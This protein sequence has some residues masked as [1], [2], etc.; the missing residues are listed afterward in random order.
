M[1][2]K[3]EWIDGVIERIESEVIRADHM[4]KQ[5]MSLKRT[6]KA[7]TQDYVNILN[8]IEN[9]YKGSR[10][11]NSV[12][13]GMGYQ[14][15][16]ASSWHGRHAIKS[17]QRRLKSANGIDTEAV[18][19]FRD[20]TA[21][22]K[23][24]KIETLR[25]EALALIL[26]SHP[27]MDYTGENQY[28]VNGKKKKISPEA[29]S[30]VQRI[31]RWRISQLTALIESEYRK[32]LQAEL[33]TAEYLF[34]KINKEQERVLNADYNEYLKAMETFNEKK[35]VPYAN[36]KDSATYAEYEAVRNAPVEAYGVEL[37]EIGHAL[38]PMIARSQASVYGYALCDRL[39]L[40]GRFYKPTELESI[41]QTQMDTVRDK[42]SSKVVQGVF[43]R[44][45][46]DVS[47]RVDRVIDLYKCRPLKD[48]KNL[49]VEQA[50]S[51]YENLVKTE[52]QDGM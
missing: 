24:S 12:E 48:I 3:P 38:V 10:M 37:S 41:C 16:A 14:S 30:A 27:H 42:L 46:K 20:M 34:N 40:D 13:Q 39:T 50:L 15:L 21:A 32:P 1:L 23:K 43:G 28:D 22:I 44:P 19:E 47:Y 35:F 33:P 6:G 31:Q 49:T 36:K 25:K 8:T 5:Y 45:R 7:T 9:F 18:I 4:Q 51:D 29:Q 52:S 2:K 11:S 26:N 17:M